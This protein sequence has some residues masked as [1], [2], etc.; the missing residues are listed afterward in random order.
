MK[1]LKKLESGIRQTVELYIP[2][3]SFV[4]M[5]CLFCYQILVRYVI[6]KFTNLVVPW[7]TEVEQSCFL[8]IALLGACYVQRNKGHVV[9]TMVYDALKLKGKAVMALISNAFVAF[10]MAITFIPSF[11][12]IW[13]L[14]SRHQVTSLLKIPKTLVF[15]PYV[16]FLFL[17]FAYNILDIYEDIMVLRG[18]EYYTKKLLRESMSEAD[19]AIEVMKQQKAEME[20]AEAA[21]KAKEE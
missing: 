21:E 7:T 18:N 8:W 20:A 6:S 17:I 1:F 10:A 14:T 2:A 12:Y 13:G 19:Q 9:F 16:I 3:I 11:K 4:V 15:F 5:C